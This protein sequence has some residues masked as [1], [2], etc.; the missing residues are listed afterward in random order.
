MRGLSPFLLLLLGLAALFA[1]AGQLLFKLGAQ[2]AS[3][4]KDFF[5]VHIALGLTSYGLGTVLWII[6]L[7]RL[8]LKVVYPFVAL[9]MVMVYLGA[10]LLLGERITPRGVAGTLVVLAGLAL[11]LVDT[12]S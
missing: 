12:G 9:T 1:T 5:N 3:H 7:S 2:N 11:I 6:T 8:P 4:L 10:A